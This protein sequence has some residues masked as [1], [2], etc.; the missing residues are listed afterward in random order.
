MGNYMTGNIK[1]GILAKQVDG[2]T[3]KNNVIKNYK[4]AIKISECRNISLENNYADGVTN[5]DDK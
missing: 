5:V 4:E 1:A 2:L 3:I